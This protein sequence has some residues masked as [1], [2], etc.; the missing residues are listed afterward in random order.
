MAMEHKLWWIRLGDDRD[1][2]CGG[3]ED[4]NVC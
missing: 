2:G 4:L 1:D 3:D